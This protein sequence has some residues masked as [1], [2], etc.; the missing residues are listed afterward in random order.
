MPPFTPEQEERLRQIV[1]EEMAARFGEALTHEQVMEV[2]SELFRS[3]ERGSAALDGDAAAFV[4]HRPVRGGGAVK[5]K[6]C[7]AALS[8]EQEG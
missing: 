1:R 2:W 8:P 5:L 7:S 6:G 4:V 3:R